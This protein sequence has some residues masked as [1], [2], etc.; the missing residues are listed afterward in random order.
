[1]MTHLKLDTN[2]LL[3]DLKVKYQ[4]IIK[5]KVD[6]KHYHPYRAFGGQ[7]KIMYS[8]SFVTR[9]AIISLLPRQ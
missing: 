2:Q 1:M 6:T 4:W 3:I 5:L 7:N 9:R 8:T